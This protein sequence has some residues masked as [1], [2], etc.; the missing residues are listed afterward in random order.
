MWGRM[1]K[2]AKM[3]VLGVIPNPFEGELSRCLPN[4]KAF[5]GLATLFWS[6]TGGQGGRILR[7]T[8]P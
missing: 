5:Q 1:G 8:P 2:E 3:T 4:T 6:R 7:Q